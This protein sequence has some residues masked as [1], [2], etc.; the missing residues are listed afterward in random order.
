VIAGWLGQLMVKVENC[1]LVGK[2]HLFGDLLGAWGEGGQTWFRPLPITQPP[3]SRET[4]ANPFFWQSCLPFLPWDYF[5]GAFRVAVLHRQCQKKKVKELGV[6][7]GSDKCAPPNF[8]FKQKINNLVFTPPQGL[9]SQ[10]GP[11]KRK[12]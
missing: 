9:S 10:G 8:F 5:L 4:T 7:C 1:V 12:S 3:S 2:I 6:R 11:K